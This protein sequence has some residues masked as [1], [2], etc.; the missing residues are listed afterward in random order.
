[1]IR[2]TLVGISALV[3]LGGVMH[4]AK[5][6]ELTTQEWWAKEHGNLTVDQFL[7]QKLYWFSGNDLFGLAV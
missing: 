3:L 5:Q 7:L 4:L 6:Q 2:T 1:M